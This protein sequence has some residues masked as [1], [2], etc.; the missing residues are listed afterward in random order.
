MYIRLQLVDTRLER[1]GQTFEWDSEKAA[2]NLRKHNVT[3]QEALR[4]LFRPVLLLRGLNCRGR[5]TRRSNWIQ[6]TLAIA[7]CCSR[8]APGR[9]D[10]HHFGSA[11]NDGRE[12]NLSA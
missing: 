11:R 8:G 12:K 7:L 10:P 2:I 3:F 1:R 9:N 5:S 6:R 4:G